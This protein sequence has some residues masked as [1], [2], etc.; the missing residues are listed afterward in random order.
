[1]TKRKYI[2][3]EDSDDGYR[4]VE[5]PECGAVINTRFQR[6]RLWR[7]LQCPVCLAHVTV[8][9]ESRNS[10]QPLIQIHTTNK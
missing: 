6:G 1:M 7:R 9:L 2:D 4:D 8:S 10:I 5:C 3:E